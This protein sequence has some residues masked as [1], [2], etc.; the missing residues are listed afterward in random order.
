M[1]APTASPTTVP[2]DELPTDVQDFTATELDFL[3]RDRRR[4]RDARSPRS[5]TRCARTCRPRSAM[6]PIER[7]RPDQL[8]AVRLTRGYT[9]HAEGSVL[10]E[11]GDTQGAVHRERRGEACRRSCKGQGQRL[12]H[13]RV[14]HAAARDQHAQRPRGGARQAVGPHAGD[15]APDRPQPARG[16]RPRRARASAPIQ[17]RLRRAAG[18][19][20]HAHR[21]DHRR[22]RRAARR[23]RAGCRTR[24]SIADDA[25]A[26][27]RRRDL[28][29][30]RTRARRCSTSTTPRTRPATPT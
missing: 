7:Q 21:V 14:R 17:H 25:A 6:R 1:R 4:H 12:G 20:R 28:G 3:R 8:R 13:R 2:C 5:R 24:A 10:V 29:R 9:R 18:R 15:P 23:A 19:R 22:L 26:R 27:F 16:R 30:H 11:F